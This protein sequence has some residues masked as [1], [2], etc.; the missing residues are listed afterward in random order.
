MLQEEGYEYIQIASEDE[1]IENLRRQLEK[2]NN[3]KFSDNEWKNFFT[4]SI[5]SKNDGIVEKTRFI[6][7]DFVKVLKTDSGEEIN[8]YFIDK[9]NINN[10]SLQVMNQYTVADYTISHTDEESKPRYGN[11]Y[12]VTILVNGFPIVHCELKR[13]GGAIRDAFNQI[14]RYAR[15]SFWVGT[16]L[17]EYVQIFVISNG[18]NTKY[19]SNTTRD[20]HIKEQTN[21]K[22]S[23][24]KTSNSYEFTSYWADA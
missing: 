15:D 20:S 23:G 22:G 6:Q 17:F 16:D 2:L 5:A 21:K 8:I 7:T 11:R 24:R 1:L 19:Y 13:R 3:Y 18:T 12:D 9:K 4:T 14:R 10:N